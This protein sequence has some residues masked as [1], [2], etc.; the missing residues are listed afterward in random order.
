ME[1]KDRY[2]IFDDR[3]SKFFS[4]NISGVREDDGGV[5]LCGVWRKDKSVSYYYYFKEIQ[6]QVTGEIY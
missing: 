6:L 3:R 4:V 5:Y 1:K 2:S